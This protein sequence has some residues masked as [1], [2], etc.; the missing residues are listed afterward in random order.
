[1]LIS[2]S[3]GLGM[4]FK[5]HIA[6]TLHNAFG[7]LI[8]AAVIAALGGLY[9][10]F[11]HHSSLTLPLW[12]VIVF[13]ALVLGL[14]TWLIL[15]IRQLTAERDRLRG[16]VQKQGEAAARYRYPRTGWMSGFRKP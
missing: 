6:P 10:L 4:R 11:T 9:A 3:L 12:L 2:F 16:K 1:M 7:G 13:L 15:R 8:A 5:D 14:L